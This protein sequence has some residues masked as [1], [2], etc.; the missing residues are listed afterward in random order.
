MRGF[1]TRREWTVVFGVTLVQ[2]GSERGDGGW[3]SLRRG[4]HILSERK[5]EIVCVNCLHWFLN[6][7]GI[8]VWSLVDVFLFI[9]SLSFAHV[10]EHS[11]VLGGPRYSK[12]TFLLRSSSYFRGITEENHRFIN[13]I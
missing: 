5:Q 8:V 2:K 1:K 6:D 7:F 10:F 12:A 3:F 11:L 4:R 9:C 13:A